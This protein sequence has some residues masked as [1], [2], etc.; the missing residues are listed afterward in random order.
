M[1]CMARALVAIYFGL[2]LVATPGLAQQ[3]EFPITPENRWV[4]DALVKMQNKGILVGYRP[5]GIERDSH[6]ARTRYVLA[7]ATHATYQKLKGMLASIQA[8]IDDLYLHRTDGA[9]LESFR[10]EL[11]DLKAQVNRFDDYDEN[12]RDLIKLSRLFSRK[13]RDQGVNV[14]R[15][16][17]ELEDMRVRYCSGLARFH[18][19]KTIRARVSSTSLRKKL[20][21]FYERSCD[22]VISTPRVLET[23][24][25]CFY[26]AP[27]K[28]RHPHTILG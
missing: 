3:D 4:I 18:S 21:V 5:F 10:A 8:R 20:I 27:L 14:L 13:L 28:Y 7:S 19:Q 6:Q 25:S 24:P 12:V 26:R 2:L 22:T 1:T 9:S 11:V 17:R 23:F 16:R 15:M